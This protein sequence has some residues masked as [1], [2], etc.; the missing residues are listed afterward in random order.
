M[1]TEFTSSLEMLGTARWSLHPV[2]LS[3]N[4]RKIAV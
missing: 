2:K 3:R 1:G 4:G